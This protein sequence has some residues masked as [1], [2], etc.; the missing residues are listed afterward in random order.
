MKSPHPGM[1]VILIAE[2]GRG[3]THAI[4]TLVEA[5]LHPL[6]I[7][8]E[9][10]FDMLERIPA[11]KLSWVY[12]N[13]TRGS[14]EDVRKQIKQVGT[15]T[16]SG[17]AKYYDP[18]R[19]V[20][21]PLDRIM[22][23]M[24]NFKCERSGK[25][26]G[27][28]STWGTNKCFVLD[29]LSGLAEASWQNVAGGRMALDKPDYQLAQKQIQ[30]LIN[31]LC[32][33]FRCHVVITAHAEMELDPIHGGHRLYPSV[34]GKALAPTLGKYFTDVV[35]AKRVGTKFLWDTADPSAALVGRN[36]PTGADLPPS[37]APMV[38]AWQAKG[39]IIET[40]TK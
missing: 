29:G 33:T 7:F 10:K 25:E 2:P 17:L 27:N 34:P 20:E 19:F 24:M 22:E 40:E 32:F 3:K 14:L 11:D 4:S 18:D 26:Y 21:S 36:L 1:K 12:V 15:Q 23:M 28:I 9:N 35:L 30:L 8:T 38:K 6:C 13:P 37:F 39:G 16:L 5:G 31:Q